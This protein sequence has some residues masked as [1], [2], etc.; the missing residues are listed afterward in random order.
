MS[1]VR[2]VAS[3]VFSNNGAQTTNGTNHKVDFKLSGGA[4]LTSIPT[5]LTGGTKYKIEVSYDNA[6][7]VNTVTYSAN[8]TF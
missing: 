8:G 6:G 1:D 2:A 7:Y 3:A 5:N 4:A